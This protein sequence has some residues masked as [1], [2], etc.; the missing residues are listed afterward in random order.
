MAVVR[1]TPTEASE[2]FN[3]GT[4]DSAP[5]KLVTVDYDFVGA[6]VQIAVM[7]KDE[8]GGPWASILLNYL[9]AEVLGRA[10]LRASRQAE[11]TEEN[12]S[13]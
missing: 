13:R 4:D 10:L 1:I 7:T 6:N 2:I 5:V 3:A 9:E 11:R 8:D 12:E